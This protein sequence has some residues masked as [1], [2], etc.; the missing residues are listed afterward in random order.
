MTAQRIHTATHSAFNADFTDDDIFAMMLVDEHEHNVH[1][2]AEE[3]MNMGDEAFIDPDR[4]WT[5]V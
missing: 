4:Y 1:H 3:D 2:L 5:V